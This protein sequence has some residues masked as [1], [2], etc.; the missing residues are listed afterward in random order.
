MPREFSEGSQP[1]VSRRPKIGV[2]A[3]SQEEFDGLIVKP[4]GGFVEAAVICARSTLQEKGNELVVAGLG[5]KEQ[6]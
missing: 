5:G 1:V 4:T 2:M 3:G 6:G